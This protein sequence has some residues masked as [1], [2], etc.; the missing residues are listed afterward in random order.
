MGEQLPGARHRLRAAPVVADAGQHA[1]TAQARG[2]RLGGGQVRGERLLHEHRHPGVRHLHLGRGLRGA[3]RERRHAD[4]HGVQALREQGPDVVDRRG[5][6]LRRRRPPPE[7]G[8]RPWPRRGRRRRTRTGPVRAGWR[9]HPFRRTRCGKRGGLPGFCVT[10]RVP[11][12]D[13]LRGGNGHRAA[14]DDDRAGERRT[15][16]LRAAA[17]LRRDRERARGAR[18]RAA[19]ARRAGGARDGR[20]QHAARRRAASPCSPTAGSRTCSG[21]TTG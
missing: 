19:Q 18:A 4:V 17:R 2:D 10:M 11:Y 5:A 20:Q 16:A 15:V 1:R 21:P 7:C 6:E 12:L 8:R 9:R 13:Y 14:Y 3:V